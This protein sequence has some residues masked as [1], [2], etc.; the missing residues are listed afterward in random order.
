M[1]KET[2]KTEIKVDLVEQARQLRLQAEELERRVAMV[3]GTR[4]KVSFV[5]DGGSTEEL[6]AT[7]Q[8]LITEHPLTFQELLERTGAR[9]NR[10]K[11]VLMRLQRE[12]V[13][14]YNIGLQSRAIW[15]IPNEDVLLKLIKRRRR[16]NTQR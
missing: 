8:R 3:K 13:K 14:V 2:R 10:I 4:D 9:D 1:R 5:G 16:E 6:M 11:G 12:G 7:V 15:F